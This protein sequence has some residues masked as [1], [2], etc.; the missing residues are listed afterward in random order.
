MHNDP[1]AR[2][3]WSIKPKGKRGGTH[4]QVVVIRSPKCLTGILKAIF[5]I[6][7]SD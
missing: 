2:I 1:Q 5:K 4:M 7:R 3:K 6:K